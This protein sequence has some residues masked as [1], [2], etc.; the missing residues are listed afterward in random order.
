MLPKLQMYQNPKS[1]P[2]LPPVSLPWSPEECENLSVTILE[3]LHWNPW[4]SCFSFYSKLQETYGAMILYAIFWPPLSFP[5]VYRDEPDLNRSSMEGFLFMIV[6]SCMS[7]CPKAI[8][9]ECVL[10]SVRRLE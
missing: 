4:E 9:I 6:E 5:F 3:L 7:P 10:N 2:V 8:L 1:G